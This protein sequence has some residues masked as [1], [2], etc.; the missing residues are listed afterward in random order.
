M[1]MVSFS[2]STKVRIIFVIFDFF[3]VVEIG[4]LNDRVFVLGT[5]PN[6]DFII[7]LLGTEL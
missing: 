5:A 3:D 6:S 1:A 7:F 2:W 4:V